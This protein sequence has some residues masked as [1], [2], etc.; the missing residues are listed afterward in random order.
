MNQ[1]S[2]YNFFFF[3]KFFFNEIHSPSFHLFLYIKYLYT[4][5]W[6]WCKA[7]TKFAIN[8]RSLNACK[9]RISCE[10]C[11]NYDNFTNIYIYKFNVVGVAQMPFGI[12]KNSIEG[13]KSKLHNSRCENWLKYIAAEQIQ[14]HLT[15]FESTF[16]HRCSLCTLALFFS[17]SKLQK[18]LIIK[19]NPRNDM[20]CE[21]IHA[22]RRWTL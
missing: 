13:I 19:W 8:F 10:I 11:F 16:T 21:I 18:R 6:Q 2:W 3:T 12:N 1:L 5:L 4:Y 9:L 17:F 22:L 14:T 20:K 15:F 7:I